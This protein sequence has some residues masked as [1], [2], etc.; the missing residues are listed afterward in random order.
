MQQQNVDSA[1]MRAY[2]PR[3]R[4]HGDVRLWSS[5]RGKNGQFAPIYRGRLARCAGAAFRSALTVW[6]DL[7]GV[8]GMLYCRVKRVDSKVR[9]VDILLKVA[10]ASM[11]CAAAMSYWHSHIC[12]SPVSSDLH[13]FAPSGLSSREA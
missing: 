13:D 5:E 4:C 11:P 6:L 10:M 12:A 1:V 7:E 8:L 3:Q 2:V 9:R